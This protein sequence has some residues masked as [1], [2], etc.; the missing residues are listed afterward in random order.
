VGKSRAVLAI[1][2]C[3]AVA[4][5]AALQA[6]IPAQDT[7][8]DTAASYI[9]QVCKLPDAQRSAALAA[10]NATIQPRRIDLTCP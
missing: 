6:L 2:A 1:L 3:M 7:T 8:A 10:M 9:V 5:C 4:G